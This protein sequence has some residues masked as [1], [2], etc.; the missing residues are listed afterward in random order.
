V[1]QLSFGDLSDGKSRADQIF[2][3]FVVFHKANPHV[4]KLFCE[5]ADDMRAYQ[6][7]YSARTIIEVIRWRID[8]TVGS[9]PVKLND[10]YSPYYARMYMATH[11][12]SEGFFELRRRTSADR[13]AYKED[14]SMYHTGLA[15]DEEALIEKL[16]ELA[17]EEDEHSG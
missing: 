5:I 11:D 8:S 1:S 4:W 7:Q 6:D 10:H 13:N 12:G 17:D 9:E 15:I 2:E 14:L 3:R 16:K